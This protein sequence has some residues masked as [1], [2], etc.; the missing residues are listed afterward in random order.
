MVEYNTRL[1]NFFGAQ[2]VPLQTQKIAKSQQETKFSISISGKFHEI[3]PVC[4]CC[5]SRS[6]TH[7]GNDECKSKIIKQLGLLIKKGK[8][9]CKNC[10]KTWTTNYEDAELFVQQYKQLINT[11]V[12]QL[13]TYGVS[14]DK[15]ARH[16]TTMFGKG[17]SHEWVRQLYIKCAKII[18]QKKVLGS[19][20]IFNYD[21]QYPKVNGKTYVRAVVID[22]VTKK[23]IFDEKVEDS[24]IETLKD[25]LNMKLLPYNKEAF[26]VDFARGYPKMLRDL[27][28][29][30]KIQFCIFHLNKLILADFE[31]S[32]RFSKAGRKLL[33]LQEIYNLY[34]IL[35]IFMDHEAEKQFLQRKLKELTRWNEIFKDY[36]IY[37]EAPTISYY[38][39]KLI[40]EFKEF[41]KGLKKNRRKHKKKYLIKKTKEESLKILEKL[42]KE[43]NL[44]PKKIQKRIKRIRKNIDCL[45]LFQENPLI[46]PTNNNIEQYYAATLQK[47]EK[48]KFRSNQS[49]QI[50]LKILREKWNHTLG[51]IKFNFIEF[52][53][54]FAR[55]KCFFGIT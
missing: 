3:N 41:R 53:Q 55:M 44:F 35:N 42:E 2:V 8:F 29:Q 33:P 52:L 14:L 31:R 18:E 16:I 19:S 6:I 12:F 37:E 20:G 45:T 43:L 34:F 47:T 21:E 10:P 39:I 49:L 4:P 25:K 32:K 30:A 5:G 22:A 50:K 9:K 23:V 24:R 15:I 17:I 26:I 51:D 36:R 28:P 7:N 48:K 54:L 11:E 38:E 13:C 27:F 40:S 1:N 46:P